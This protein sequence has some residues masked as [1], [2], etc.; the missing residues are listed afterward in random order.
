M[1][2]MITKSPTHFPRLR[3]HQLPGLKLRDET[4][5][6]TI[7]SFVSMTRRSTTLVAKTLRII[8]S[9]RQD[10]AT[11]QYRPTRVVTDLSGLLVHDAK[12][13]ARAPFRG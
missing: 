8:W 3:K 2:K 11:I 12:L 9:L 13:Y 7:H 6:A 1:G 10:E 4:G 5:K